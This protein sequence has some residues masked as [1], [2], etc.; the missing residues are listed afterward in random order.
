MNPCDHW[1]T[2]ERARLLRDCYFVGRR[3]KAQEGATGVIVGDDRGRLTIH[4][5][6]TDHFVALDGS[7]LRIAHNI[8]RLDVEVEILPASERSTT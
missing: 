3:L 8:P 4:F 2:I 7:G 6:D 1:K 5:D